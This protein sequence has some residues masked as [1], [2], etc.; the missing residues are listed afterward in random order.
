M[1]AFVTG[2]AVPGGDI[3]TYL[4]GCWKRS[5]ECRRFGGEF[6][7]L[8]TGNSIIAIEERTAQQMAA[9]AAQQQPPYHYHHGSSSLG[10]GGM[11][12]AAPKDISGHLW[13][14]LARCA[15]RLSE[16]WLS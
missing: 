14:R 7:H 16:P 10:A 11:M 12:A 1:S 5:V 3:V 9:A 6:H 15:W 8:R 13:A 2:Y 4:R